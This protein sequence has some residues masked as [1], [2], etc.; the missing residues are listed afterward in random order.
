MLTM[1]LMIAGA[2][3]AGT[4]QVAPGITLVPGQFVAD[5]GP[6]G[7]SIFIGAPEGLILIDTG[8]HPE[9]RDK[10]IAYAKARKR[11]IAAI[12]NTHWHLDH[13]TGNGDI[14]AAYPRAQ[15][16]ATAAVDGALKTFLKE[17]RERTQARVAAGEVPAERKAEVQR[18][19]G[20]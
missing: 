13:A 2:A 20:V 1:S 11:P 14:L 6:D 18:F 4:V 12:L 9:H 3:A 15:V 8:R 5:K 10:L 17:S 16:Y 19:L 7:N